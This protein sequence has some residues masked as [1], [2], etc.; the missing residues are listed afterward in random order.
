MADLNSTIVRGNLRVTEDINT[1]G[2]IISNGSISATTIYEDGTALINKYA[3][4]YETKLVNTA[5]IKETSSVFIIS[6]ITNNTFLQIFPLCFLSN[7]INRFTFV[8][9]ECWPWCWI[10][11]D[12]I[13]YGWQ[14]C[15]FIIKLNFPIINNCCNYRRIFSKY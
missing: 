12:S 13:W 10:A 4:K 11:F 5:G 2:D 8:C 9:K 3:T 1:N 15:Y 7:L 14:W 6:C